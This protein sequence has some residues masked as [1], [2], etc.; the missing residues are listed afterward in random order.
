MN[1]RKKH[2]ALTAVIAAAAVCVLLTAAAAFYVKAALDGSHGRILENVYI[3]SIDVGGMTKDEAVEA[4]ETFAGHVDKK[5]VITMSTGDKAKEIR[6]ARFDIDYKSLRSADMAYDV[7]RKGNVFSR[8][9]DIRRLKTDK[10]T[11]VLETAADPARV[12][13]ILKRSS[14]YFTVREKDADLKNSNGRV[15]IIKERY[16]QILDR[17]KSAASLKKDIREKWGRGRDITVKLAVI[18]QKPKR[19]AADLQGMTDVLGT[20][21]TFYD[22]DQYNRCLNI[23]R[24]TA[25]ISGTIV[26]PGSTF[27]VYKKVKPFTADN[28]YY[29]APTISGDKHEDD[30]GGGIC[31]V[32]TTLYNAVIRSEL[33]IKERHNHTQAIYYV[34]LSADAAIAGTSYDLKFMNDMKDAIYIQ[35]RAKK[36][37]VRFTVYGKDDRDR[38][39]SVRFESVVLAVH[40]HGKKVVEKDPD[41]ERG[42]ERIK[43]PG[44]TGYDA[45]LWKIVLKNGEEVKRMLFNSSH[46]KTVAEKV[47]K[48]TKKTKEKKKASGDDTGSL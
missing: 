10:K 40:K 42:K 13:S 39:R 5:G 8:F 28:G 26:K 38:S 4:A 29:L 34:P 11:V 12:N 23:A 44:A 25:L 19:M 46:Y 27:S 2:A 24:G 31:Q 18:K 16:G 30:Y 15:S 43:E 1:T 48:G 7:G 35:G 41:L 45:Q 6:A 33:K 22:K 20:Y 9:F 47:I 17:K 14:R 21:E 37:S 3:S 36:S 32:S